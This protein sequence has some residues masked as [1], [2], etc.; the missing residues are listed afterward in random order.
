MLGGK[1]KGKKQNRPVSLLDQVSATTFNNR[2]KVAG[3]KRHQSYHASKIREF[4]REAKTQASR[5][6]GSILPLCNG[7]AIKFYS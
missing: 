5:A 2:L 1:H 6:R 7:K 4:M 3:K